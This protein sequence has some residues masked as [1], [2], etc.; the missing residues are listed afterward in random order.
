MYD[1]EKS[2]GVGCES[3]MD[4]VKKEFLT[5]GK[6]RWFLQ[7]DAPTEEDLIIPPKSDTSGRLLNTSLWQKL[8]K[9]AIDENNPP[10]CLNL[11]LEDLSDEHWRSIPGFDNRFVISNKGRV[12][13]LSGWTSEGRKIFLRE[14]TISQ[15]MSVNSKTTYSLYCLLRHKRMNTRITITKMLYY[16]FVE[17]F[18]LNNNTIVVANNNNP[19]WNIE[20]SNLSL[21]P[22]YDVLKKKEI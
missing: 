6:F 3:I 14:Q 19:L 5:A 11:S 8:G 21:R 4:A 12:K 15:I 16:C 7:S 13:R 1:A 22:I 9:P 20:L 2:V 17:K 10:P 18:N